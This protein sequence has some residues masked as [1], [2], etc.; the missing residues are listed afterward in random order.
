[1]QQLVLLTLTGLA[2]LATG[3]DQSRLIPRDS[4]CCDILAQAQ[5]E[6]VHACKRVP[7]PPHTDPKEYGLPG[8]ASF[9]KEHIENHMICCALK[10]D[11]RAKTKLIP[12]E[13]ADLRTECGCDSGE[14]VPRDALSSV[15]AAGAPLCQVSTG[16]VSCSHRTTQIDGRNVYYQVPEGSAPNGGWPAVIIFH[17]W[18]LYAENSWNAN[19]DDTYGVY[20]K[21]LLVKNLLEA[22]YAVITPNAVKPGGYWYTNVA[23][24]NTDHQSDLTA[25]NASSPDASLL[26]QIFAKMSQWGMNIGNLHCAGFSSGGYMA[27]RMVDNY[28][29]CKTVSINS[30]SYYYCGGADCPAPG[31]FDTPYLKNEVPTLFLQGTADPIVPPATQQAYYQKLQSDGRTTERILMQGAG[32]QWV[33]QAPTAIL[34]WIQKRGVGSITV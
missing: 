10:L 13:F 11:W 26:K 3:H 25:W 2:L 34:D 17:G 8:N 23:P 14:A 16:V 6:A 29:V 15:P 28:D 7:T 1:M 12:D 18:Y 4:V 27:A 31:Q 5:N 32:H 20:N 33:D 30:G 22:G 24:Y 19:Y 21:A 9:C